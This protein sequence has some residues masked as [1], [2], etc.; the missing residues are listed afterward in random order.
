MITFKNIRYEEVAAEYPEDIKKIQQAISG[1][2]IGLAN[3]L[4]DAVKMNLN[5]VSDN[6]IFLIED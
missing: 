3:L 5:T 6:T 1:L 4:I 2:P